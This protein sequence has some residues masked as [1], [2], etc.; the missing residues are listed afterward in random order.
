METI[1][2]TS[3]VKL[4]QFKS[5]LLDL[6]SNRKDISIRLELKGE[7]WT[8]NFSTVLVFSRQELILTHLPTRTIQYIKDVNDIT[9]FELDRPYIIFERC[10]HYQITPVFQPFNSRGL[11]YG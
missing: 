7:L 9:A 6:E 11:L 8:E 1:T 3:G 5:L 2:T 4:E 10:K